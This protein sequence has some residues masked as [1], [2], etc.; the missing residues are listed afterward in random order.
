MSIMRGFIFRAVKVPTFGLGGHGPKVR[1]R[2][3]RV[4]VACPD[5]LL[6]SRE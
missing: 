3:V 5:V 1:R 6:G 4:V 2:E